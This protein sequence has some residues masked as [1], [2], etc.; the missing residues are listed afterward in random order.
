M[1]HVMKFTPTK[2][3]RKVQRILQASAALVQDGKAEEE[4]NWDPNSPWH[5][6]KYTDL[7]TGFQWVVYLPDHAFPG[8]VKVI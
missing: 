1:C 6:S 8:E 3:P 7:E 2:D 5:N 4:L